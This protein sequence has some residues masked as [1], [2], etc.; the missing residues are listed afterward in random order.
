VRDLAVSWRRLDVPG[1]DSARLHHQ[2]GT[3]RLKGSANFTDKAG[4]WDMAYAVECASDWTTLRASIS[5]AHNGT[6]LE[7]RVDR[8][9]EGRWSLNGH[10][11][12]EVTGCADIDLA[13]TPATNLL[14][15]RR[16][17]LAVGQEAEVA[18]AWL[19]FPAFSLTRL[20]QRYRRI[21]PARYSY[22]AP[23]LPFA[24]VLTVSEGG[25]VDGYPGLWRAEA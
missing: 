10:E 7:Y 20:L 15:V 16:L 25:F 17:R 6:P 21:A 12:P 5:G 14:P 8:A 24:A 2:G 11:V 22:S 4:Q 1:V 3:W 23:A 9:P 18:A 13:F 19:T